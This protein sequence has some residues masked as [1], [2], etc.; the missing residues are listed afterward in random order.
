M[1]PNDN[2]GRIDKYT[3]LVSLI[4]WLYVHKESLADLA[5]TASIILFTISVLTTIART[6]IRLRYHK[7]LFI[8]DAFLFA[9]VVCLCASMSLLIRSTSD[10]YMIEALVMKSPTVEMPP[11]PIAQWILLNKLNAAYSVLTWTT[12]VAVKF[13]FLSFF[14]RLI[15]GLPG[16]DDLLVDHHHHH[17]R[18]LGFWR[19]G[20]LPSLP[21]L[22]SQKS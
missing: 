3:F 19:G 9:A 13:S 16:N 21:I 14:R 5:K 20:C 22:L 2:A 17:S 15:N 1:S 7:R 18:R 10:M 11:D 8:D 6:V 4:E 12:L